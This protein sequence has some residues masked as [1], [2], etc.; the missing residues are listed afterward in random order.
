MALEVFPAGDPDSNPYLHPQ[1]TAAVESKRDIDSIKAV[2]DPLTEVLYTISF[3]GPNNIYVYNV[4]RGVLDEWME[5]LL[6][7]GM[8]VN[9]T[10]PIRIVQIYV[11][12][13]MSEGEVIPVDIPHPQY[14]STPQ[15]DVILNLRTVE[16]FA[17]EADGTR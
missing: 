5:E 3:H 6:A 10:D 12:A 8:P 17:V 4:T 9:I 14:G 16:H 7:E 1:T 11:G 15:R 2:D 13:M